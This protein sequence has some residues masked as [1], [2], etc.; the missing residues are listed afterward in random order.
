MKASSFAGTPCFTSSHSS[1]GN[2]VVHG[3]FLRCARDMV[4]FQNAPDGGVRE[5]DF[6]RMP[7]IF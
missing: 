2:A 6:D 7:K 5:N 3:S 4:V 1:S